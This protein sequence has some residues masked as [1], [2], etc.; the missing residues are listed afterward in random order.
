MR[1]SN[2]VWPSG[3]SVAP[4]LNTVLMAYGQSLAERIGFLGCLW[5]SVSCLFWG[6]YMAVSGRKVPA[7]RR[8]PPLASRATWGSTLGTGAGAKA[9]AGG[10]NSLG[11]E[12]L[13]EAFLAVDWLRCPLSRPLPAPPASAG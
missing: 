6:V 4:A 2:S 3:K 11:P 8:T 10:T 1:Q 12:E 9:G 7:A 5:K 13:V